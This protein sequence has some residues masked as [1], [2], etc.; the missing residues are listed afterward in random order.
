MYQPCP[1]P[2]ANSA[3]GV[4]AIQTALKEI[5]GS[6][7][8]EVLYDGTVLQGILSSI[9]API[10]PVLR[11][12]TVAV[13]GATRKVGIVVFGQVEH[14]AQAELLQVI[15]AVDLGGF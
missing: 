5:S 8:A 1:S 6:G 9:G 3:F 7:R 14:G 15:E 13:A 11:L 12:K 4:V 10:D 2:L